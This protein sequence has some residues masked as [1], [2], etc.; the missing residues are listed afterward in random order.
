MITKEQA[1]ELRRHLQ[2]YRQ[3]TR[4]S[5]DYDQWR[6][7]EPVYRERLNKRLYETRLA[8]ENYIDELTEK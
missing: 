5:D 4:E 7:P 6:H 3:A 2:D 8:V 1:A